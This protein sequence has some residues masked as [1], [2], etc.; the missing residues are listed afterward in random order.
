[1]SMV[2]RSCGGGDSCLRASLM[3]P[4]IALAAGGEAAPGSP[5]E[6]SA[7]RDVLGCV[8]GGLE[9][10]RRALLGEMLRYLCLTGCGERGSDAKSRVNACDEVMVFGKRVT[11]AWWR[12]ARVCTRVARRAEMRSQREEHLFLA[13]PTLH[14]L[15]HSLANHNTHPTCPFPS[16][17]SEQSYAYVRSSTST[18][19][20]KRVLA[21]SRGPTSSSSFS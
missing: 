13:E 7:R 4:L 2:S 21:S 9:L 11:R 20:T 6:E 3:L 8:M 1:M 12:G 18:V 10:L 5:E 16:R 15:T 14:S 17:T 19:T